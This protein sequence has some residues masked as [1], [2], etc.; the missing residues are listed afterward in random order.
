MYH[1]DLNVNWSG[2]TIGSRNAMVVPGAQPYM[3]NDP[4][5]VHYS[6]YFRPQYRKFI[7]TPPAVPDI[8]DWRGTVSPSVS[9]KAR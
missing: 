4:S 5:G 6:H 2:T 1:A 3:L 7:P 9:S 8:I